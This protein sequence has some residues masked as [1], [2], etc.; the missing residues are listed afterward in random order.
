VFDHFDTHFAGRY[1]HLLDV[2]VWAARA[3]F[4]KP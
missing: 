3:G 2:V 4:T 1:D